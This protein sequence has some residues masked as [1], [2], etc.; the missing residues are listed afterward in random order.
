MGALSLRRAAANERSSE[1]GGSAPNVQALAQEPPAPVV[2]RAASSPP[3][4]A[5]RSAPRGALDLSECAVVQLRAP[6]VAAW[7]AFSSLDTHDTT[8]AQWL[9]QCFVRTHSQVTVAAPGPVR[10][11]L[12]RML[13]DGDQAA[14]EGQPCVDMHSLAVAASLLEPEEWRVLCHQLRQHRVDVMFRLPPPATTNARRVT[15]V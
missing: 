3:A 11:R 15:H 13:E 7:S 2:P 14:F 6:L 5:L 12:C 1:R 10:E 8:G 4:L 9:D